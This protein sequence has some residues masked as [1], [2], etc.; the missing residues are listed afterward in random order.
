MPPGGFTRLE[1]APTDFDGDG[2]EDLVYLGATE[3]FVAPSSGRGST[4]KAPTAKPISI[5]AGIDP[6]GDGDQEMFVHYN[7]EEGR[8]LVATFAGCEVRFA[9]NAQGRPYEFKVGGNE[10][11]GDGV[12][13]IDV[14]GDGRQELVGLH[15]EWR[16]NTAP[17]TRTVVRLDGGKAVNGPI[18]SGTYVSPGDDDRIALLRQATCGD[19]TQLRI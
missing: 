3:V 14:N 17:W 8:V 1:D 9:T 16:G 11:G 2:R 15:F 4:L 5:M 13:C 19:R 7:A 12:G 6:D 10:K 18:D